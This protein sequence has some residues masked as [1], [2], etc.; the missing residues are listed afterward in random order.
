MLLDNLFLYRRLKGKTPLVDLAK[1]GHSKSEAKAVDAEARERNA[2]SRVA[3][4]EN[5][6]EKTESDGKLLKAKLA[7]W[8]TAHK[9]LKE[10]LAHGVVTSAKNAV[11][12]Y[13]RSPEFFEEMA[14]N[15]EPSFKAGFT[16]AVDTIKEKLNPE[17]DVSQF[18]KYDPT[19]KFQEL[20]YR[21]SSTLQGRFPASD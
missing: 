19:A 16:Y 1:T 20:L 15:L 4:L 6:L 8:E 21:M 18:D 5:Q 17:L 13:K 11:E 10:E 3:Q 7:Y 12:S 14:K 2:L 9:Q